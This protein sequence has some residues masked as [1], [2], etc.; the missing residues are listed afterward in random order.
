MEQQTSKPEIASQKRAIKFA[1]A[2]GDWTTYKPPKVLVKKVKSGLYGFDRLSKEE[3]NRFL[4]IHYCF[5]QELLKRFKRDLGMAE[6]LFAVQ[7]E[8]TTYLNFLRTLIGPVVQCK[9]SVPDLHEPILLFLDIALAN[10]IINY[11]L[12]SVDLDPINRSLTEAEKTALTTTLSEYL[13]SLSLAFDGA[14]ANLSLTITGS[15]DVVI[16]Q[17]INP[18][19]T[20]AIYSAEIS[21]ADNPPARLF[22]VYPGHALTNLLTKFKEK[23]TAK[24]LDFSRFPATLLSKVMVNTIAT[25][26]ET[27]L[28]MNNINELAVGDVVSLETDIT[29][30]LLTTIGNILKLSGQPGLK[31][32]KTAVRLV[33][34]KEETQPEIAPPRLADD[35]PEIKK[36]PPPLP[37]PERKPAERKFLPTIPQPAKTQPKDDILEE[38]EDTLDDFSEEDL[39]D[40]FL[41][42]EL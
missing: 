4:F 32:K 40:D 9:I 28:T 7:V 11:A 13:P 3:L 8:Q 10:S 18:T 5:T 6:E 2:I 16:D 42:E 31:N 19:S 27:S 14:L 25:L 26:G 17:T 15:P 29:S 35:R 20:M 33:G 22:I 34:L 1:P 21:L 39:S 36:T 38:E 23:E 12:G 24:P 37:L 30:P 41:D